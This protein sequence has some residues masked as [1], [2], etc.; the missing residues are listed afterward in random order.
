[1]VSVKNIGKFSQ[2]NNFLRENKDSILKYLDLFK[3]I[4]KIGQEGLK[5]LER[6]ERIN[7]TTK[8]EESKSQIEKEENTEND[9]ME[10]VFSDFEIKKEN[11]IRVYK[12]IQ[13][14]VGSIYSL[15]EK[16]DLLFIKDDVNYLN[17]NSKIFKQILEDMFPLFDKINA[18][19]Q[20]YSIAKIIKNLQRISD[21]L[22]DNDI[23]FKN[24]FV[25]V[26]SMI[27]RIPPGAIRGNSLC[28]ML[29]EDVDD[30]NERK[31]QYL[32]ILEK[33]KDSLI[34]VIEPILKKME[35]NKNGTNDDKR[36]E[37]KEEEKM[38]EEKINDN[39]EEKKEEKIDAMK[40]E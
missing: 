19:T 16:P 23:S 6:L 20:H 22:R 21:T 38:E 7:P 28:D 30:V 17:S 8:D 12:R 26:N 2:V 14:T 39:L 37:M 15:G 18:Q 10:E 1:M 3:T 4:Q 33:E 32:E 29:G 5:N 27:N 40:T 31:K 34:K 9:D 25:F 35:E 36:E 11:L 13:T 24:F